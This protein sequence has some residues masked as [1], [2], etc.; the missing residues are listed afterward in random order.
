ML[1]GAG[2]VSGAGAYGLSKLG[3][4]SFMHMCMRVI[5]EFGRWTLDVGRLTS[6][7]WRLG[8][9]LWLFFSYSICAFETI[10]VL[11]N[12][13]YGKNLYFSGP[14]QYVMPRVQGCLTMLNKF[15]GFFTD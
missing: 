14:A 2:S 4:Y 10:Y 11:Y 5:G 6:D 8:F 3:N 13:S 12:A 1:F 9:G 15:C 7:V